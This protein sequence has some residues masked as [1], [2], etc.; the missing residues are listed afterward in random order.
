M[1]LFHQYYQNNHSQTLVLLHSGG[2]AGVEWK[3]QIKPLSKYFNVLVPD[4]LGHGQ[5]LI[6]EGKTLSIALMAQTVIDLLVEHNISKA[7]I[8]GSSMGGAVALWIA[9]NAPHVLDKLVVYRIG[10]SKSSS[11]Y[12]Q[13]TDMAN[14]EY[15]RQYGMHTWLSK[16]HLPQGGETAWESVIAR[17]SAVLHPD[18]SDHNHR[19]TDLQS[20]QAETLLIA[21]D[22]DPLVPLPT[23][24]AM[25]ES[26]PQA[27]LW[28]MPNATH[29]TASNTWRAN[30]FAEEVIRFLR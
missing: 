8:L 12:E 30:A 4:L 3:P 27:A 24:F 22:R 28:V 11:T 23:L 15:W 1:T 9:I 2:M 29:I 21:G 16:L 14:P 13:T 7:H 17:V 20:I 6:P 19:L 18:N 5:S 25:Y 26:I 10:Y